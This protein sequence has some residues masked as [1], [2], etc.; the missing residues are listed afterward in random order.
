MNLK[1]EGHMQEISSRNSSF[2][3]DFLVSWLVK[4]SL[5]YL[6][7]SLSSFAF[8]LHLRKFLAYGPQI[9]KCL[10]RFWQVVNSAQVFIKI[11]EQNIKV[12]LQFNLYNDISNQNSFL[13]TIQYRRKNLWTRYYSYPSTP[14]PSWF[15][16][17]VR[18]CHHRH[19][20]KK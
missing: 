6:W 13:S 17:N 16:Q 19:I 5:R 12:C 18:E 11:Y 10:Y 20:E 2:K 15:P 3:E 4:T 14:L 1:Y 8:F 7:R 9:H